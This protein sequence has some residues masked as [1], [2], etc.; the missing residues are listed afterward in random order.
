VHDRLPLNPYLVA[1]IEVG[2]V[3]PDGKVA[4]WTPKS[5]LEAANGRFRKIMEASRGGTGAP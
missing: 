1:P 2:D 4:E 5:F 3:D